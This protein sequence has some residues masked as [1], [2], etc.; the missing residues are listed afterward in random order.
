MPTG[1]GKREKT[2]DA[3][4]IISGTKPFTE[5]LLVIRKQEPFDK[6]YNWN[7]KKDIPES[8]FTGM[9]IK[10]KFSTQLVG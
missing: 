6:N 1:R 5:S 9:S 3:S 2:T 8:F 10:D 7:I 4:S